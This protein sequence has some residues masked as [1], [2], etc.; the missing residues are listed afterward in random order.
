VAISYDDSFAAACGNTGVITR[1]WTA[2]DD[3]GNSASCVQII[4]IVDTTP[5]VL[6][7]EL[8]G[9]T[10][11]C[12]EA[13]MW[14]TPVFN[15]CSDITLTSSDFSDLNVCGNGTITRTWTATDDC[16]N[17]ASTTQV[18]TI[19]DCGDFEL[20]KTTNDIVDPTQDWEFTLYGSESGEIAIETTLGDDDGIL[21]DNVGPLSASETY[22]ICETVGAGW[23]GYWKID[24]DG[25]GF[26][27]TIIDPYSTNG[28]DLQADNSTICFDFGFGTDYPLPVGNTGITCTLVISVE[29]S[30]P[31]GAPR[32]PGYWK[33]YSSCSGGNQYEKA[34]ERG[35]C[36]EGWCTLDELIAEG[37]VFNC[38]DDAGNKT[39]FYQVATCED[40]VNLLDARDIGTGKK[41]ASDAAYTLMRALLAARLNFAAGACVTPEVQE[42][43]LEAEALL[44]SIG[45]DGSGKYLRPKDSEYGLALELANYLD[46]YNNGE[47]CDGDE[48]ARMADATESTNDNFK[49]LEDPTNEIQ[50]TAYPNPY[51]DFANFEFS[52]PFDGKASLDIYT[53]EGRHVKNLYNDDVMKDVV[54]KAY[55][56][57]KSLPGA[58]YLYKLST[59]QGMKYGT[60]IPINR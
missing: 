6:K 29:N 24:T 31:G 47:Y 28:T 37:I 9:L 34:I 2:T 16:G 12:N 10:P 54:Y 3:C 14:D 1:T 44:C 7:A 4:T 41:M 49:I 45:F 26:P 59:D 51:R 40:G 20:V 55:L 13:I 11:L 46:L 60:I 53:M 52:V 18:A 22:T 58:M 25:D 43:A 33:N 42:K 32:T 56:D 38:T 48:P 15:D 30:F 19:N 17:S 5:P 57:A 21:F 39:P 50:L 35:G 8:D 36:D 27:D 23:T